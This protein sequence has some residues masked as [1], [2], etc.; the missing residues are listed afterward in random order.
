M[1]AIVLLSYFF[2]AQTS[3]KTKHTHFYP[4]GVVVTHS[5]PIDAN[6]D[7]PINNHKHSKA[8]ICFFSVVHFGHFNVPEFACINFTPTEKHFDYPVVEFQSYTSQHI[9]TPDSRGSPA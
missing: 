6:G 3:I 4:N 8:E 5:H 7:E 1:S 2:I 9:R